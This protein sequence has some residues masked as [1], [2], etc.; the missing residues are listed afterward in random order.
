MLFGLDFETIVSTIYHV[1][2]SY[3][4][5]YYFILSTIASIIKQIMQIEVESKA[6]FGVFKIDRDSVPTLLLLA[7][8]GLM[9]KF[10]S[11]LN[12][13]G[14]SVLVAL[15]CVLI[16][17]ILLIFLK[18]IQQRI[19]TRAL[20]STYRQRGINTQTD[21]TKERNK[22][23]VR[24]THS[25]YSFLLLTFLL[26]LF[27][28]IFSYFEFGYLSTILVAGLMLAYLAIVVW[29]RI[30]STYHRTKRF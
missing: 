9:Y 13:F 30:L 11:W 15:T 20:I 6:D 16:F 22:H 27:C 3:I 7:W 29:D 21:D 1:P 26:A 18:E 10:V 24:T 4:I 23:Y 2:V 14:S 8:F 28:L 17:V 12:I 25:E 5:F 19:Q